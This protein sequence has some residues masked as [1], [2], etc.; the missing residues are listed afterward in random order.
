MSPSQEEQQRQK[1]VKPADRQPGE[2]YDR[3]SYRVAVLNAIKKGNKTL[4]QEQNRVYFVSRQEAIDT[5]Y[6]PCNNCKP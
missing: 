5:G 3:N 4:P 2:F 1:A 6:R